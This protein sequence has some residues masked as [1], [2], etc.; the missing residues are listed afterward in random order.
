M[1]K[2]FEVLSEL[3][4]KRIEVFKDFLG[5]LKPILRKGIVESLKYSSE[6]SVTDP[7]LTTIYNLLGYFS[8]ETGR[9]FLFNLDDPDLIKRARKLGDFTGL[10]KELRRKKFENY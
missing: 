8:T 6:V 1:K 3:E 2:H 4:E 5:E 7:E 10:K 9:E